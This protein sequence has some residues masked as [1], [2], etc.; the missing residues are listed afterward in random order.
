M[1]VAEILKLVE[2]ET[3][4]RIIDDE[5]GNTLAIDEKPHLTNKF[6]NNE[7]IGISAGLDDGE[8]TFDIYV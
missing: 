4:I 6:N 1:K 5:G 3:L 2:Q 7:I 8:C